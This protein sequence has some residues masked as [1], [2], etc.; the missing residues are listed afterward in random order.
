MCPTLSCRE[1]GATASAVGSGR[2]PITSDS[3]PHH[4]RPGMHRRLRN[5]VLPS[6]AQFHLACRQWRPACPARPATLRCLVPPT[7]FRRRLRAAPLHPGG[8]PPPTEAPFHLACRL[9]VWPSCR[10]AALRCRVGARA[11][12][13]VGAPTACR[14]LWAA[15]PAAPRRRRSDHGGVRRER[16]STPSP[17]R[18]R[19][20]CPWLGVGSG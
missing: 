11:R 3:A 17:P 10:P 2:L 14:R 9:A 8:L 19:T 13:P 1:R 15:S 4:F 7:A 18:S 5:D 16:A 20:W 12:C 6:E